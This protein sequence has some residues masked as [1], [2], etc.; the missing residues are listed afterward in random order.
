MVQVEMNEKE[1][2]LWK[3]FVLDRKGS[4]E[5]LADEADD[6]VSIEEGPGGK[7]RAETV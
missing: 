2:K 3:E 6:A 5:G 4:L 1:F 7:I